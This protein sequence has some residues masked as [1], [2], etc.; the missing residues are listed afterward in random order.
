MPSPKLTEP[1]PIVAIKG[2]AIT[3]VVLKNKGGVVET[4]SIDPALP[5]GFSLDLENNTCV[6]NGMSLHISPKTTY[7]ITAKNRDGACTITITLTVLEAQTKTQRGAIIE[8]H[9]QRQDLETPRSQ[10]AEAVGDAAIMHSNIKPHE[11]F[12]TQPMSDDK[13]LSQQT[14][15]NP[16]AE[17]RAQQSPEL[18][19]SPSAKLQAQ[20]VNAARPNITPTAKPG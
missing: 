11:K 3:P 12:K 7:T 1:K 8:V 16:D 9:D 17:H 14:A 15:N 5:F 6:L 20:A 19:P 13:R 2:F 10:I 18:T 4:C